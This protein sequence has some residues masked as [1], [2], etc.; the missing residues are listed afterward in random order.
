[1]QLNTHLQ[2]SWE[3]SASKLIAAAAASHHKKTFPAPNTPPHTSL[4]FLHSTLTCT[5]KI[6]ARPAPKKH[7]SCHHPLA[8]FGGLFPPK[9]CHTHL[10]PQ[11]HYVK[12][13]V[14]VQK[15]TLPAFSARL[16]AFH[17]R[18]RGGRWGSAKCRGHFC[19]QIRIMQQKKSAIPAEFLV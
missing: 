15:Y 7:A 14:F 17:C 5:Q 18:G 13:L 1:M 2:V 8:K 12:I 19:S 3:A 10:P 16:R 4:H 9:I 11:S 6:G